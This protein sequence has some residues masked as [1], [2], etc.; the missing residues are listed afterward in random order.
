M[1]LKILRASGP[2]TV[3]FP[4]FNGVTVVGAGDVLADAVTL[5]RVGD[6][7]TDPGD[8]TYVEG[9]PDALAYCAQLE[10]LESYTDGDPIMLYVRMS[11]ESE[12]HSGT[13]SDVFIFL[14]DAHPTTVNSTYYRGQF[15]GSSY[16]TPVSV[17]PPFDGTIKTW[18]APLVP[19]PGYT[20]ADCVAVLM[21]GTAQL[22][23][24]SLHINDAGLLHARV[25]EAWVEVGA[26]TTSP[27]PLRRYPRSDGLG[28]GPTRHYPRTRRGV[29][30]IV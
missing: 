11:L 21:S 26:K 14:Q 30:G 9:D 15:T 5:L 24:N 28:I 17:S 2:L 3:N 27:P 4:D 1:S 13:D 19:R 25:Y 29:G 8:A 6:T 7:G 12:G 10:P 23:F 20:L 18:A 22:A 16:N